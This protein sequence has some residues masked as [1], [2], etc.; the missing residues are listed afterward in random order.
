MSARERTSPGALPESQTSA[1]QDLLT[2]KA[3][4]SNVRTRSS[5]SKSITVASPLRS[6]PPNDSIDVQHS[7]AGDDPAKDDDDDSE[8][9]TVLSSPV[10][11]R[12]ALRR[13]NGVKTELDESSTSIDA[14]VR[15]ASTAKE[16]V[17]NRDGQE[18]GVAVEGDKADSSKGSDEVKPRRKTQKKVVS[19]RREEDSDD[20]SEL[21]DLDEQASNVVSASSKAD[22]EESLPRTKRELL[23]SRKRKYRETSAGRKPVAAE[24]TKRQRRSSAT[25]LNESDRS[26][27]EPP[28]ARL[29]RMKRGDTGNGRDDDKDVAT[30][31]KQN[32]R[33]RRAASH[34]PSREEK[35]SDLWNSDSDSENSGHPSLSRTTRGI[36]RSVS[37]PGRPMPREHK[38]HVNKYGFTRLA[39]A[40]ENGDLDMV[41]EWLEKDREQL[42]IRDNAGNSPLQIASLNGYPEIVQFLLDTGCNKDCANIDNDTP[43]ID[44]VEN[45]HLDVVRVLLDAGVDPLHQN[46]KGQQAL[47]VITDSTDDGPEIR[48]LLK[49][50]IEARQ[51]QGIRA[52]PAAEVDEART[53]R[54]GPKQLLHF[55]A[56]TPENL[57]KLVSNT[58]RNGVIEF[59]NAR[60]PVDN[61]IVAAAAK[62]GD[63]YLINLLLADMSPKKAFSKAE[64]P[65]LAVLGTSHFE[66]VKTLTE[67]EQFDPLWRAKATGKTWHEFA[68]ERSGPHWQQERDL[69]LKLFTEAQ[70]NKQLNSSPR[71]DFKSNSRRQKSPAPSKDSDMDEDEPPD[72]SRTKRR[73]VSRKDLRATTS[74]KSPSTE[75]SAAASSPE[76]VTKEEPA[77]DAQPSKR[78]PGRPRTKSL[79]S[80]PAVELKTKRMKVAREN[81]A[82]FGATQSGNS[83]TRKPSS[84][85]N[86][87]P[88][89]ESL[90]TS[91]RNG[92][93]HNEDTIMTDAKAEEEK[94][95]ALRK[96]AEDASR[97]E[98]AEKAE[99]AARERA[100]A[101]HR[102]LERQRKVASFP[103]ALQYALSE[104]FADETQPVVYLVQHFCP[105]RAVSGRLIGADGPDGEA[106]WMPS[107]QAAGLLRGAAAE[108]LLD[109]NPADGSPA[110]DRKL[111]ASLEKMPFKEDHRRAVRIAIGSTTLAKEKIER[112]LPKDAEDRSN[113]AKRNASKA[114]D[115][116]MDLECQR[117]DTMEP[118]HWIKVKAFLAVKADLVQDQSDAYPHLSQI[119]P[120]ELADTSLNSG[121][122][123]NGVTKNSTP[124]NYTPSSPLSVIDDELKSK[125]GHGLK[126][127]DGEGPRFFT[128]GNTKRF[129]VEVVRDP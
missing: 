49:K 84:S 100:E 55:M 67:L 70:G 101:E 103:T 43:L 126:L 85:S 13:T 97:R 58:D 90:G 121:G 2:S 10:K 76:A 66:V 42:E 78:K 116:R 77:E 6:S 71:S 64:K 22:R 110:T 128:P 57:L 98:E 19:R 111:F 99:K 30:E 69:L 129:R 33:S 37:T 61:N 44:S 88:A 89:A 95:E 51:Q 91:K 65:M 20:D 25:E 39:E 29:R 117:F 52:A 94:A 109:L 26:S 41:K 53:D 7:E 127:G 38:R 35:N 45:G 46:R 8:A 40:C 28:P 120:L 114:F 102:V 83:K 87:R 122:F 62:T 9:E 113:E 24:S 56:R 92:A 75:S 119:P 23:S 108:E 123:G 73:L 118:L 60:V 5:R 72:T 3:G 18:K 74:R 106:L 80:H 115:R 11:R 96:E 48:D 86:H 36:N 63:L 50:A 112:F 54:L 34:L 31:S 104:S 79:S 59:L 82:M 17:E 47:D 105:F 21:S 93:K 124:V 1:P 14:R 81:I 15:R 12:E 68:V 125:I 107:Y 27:T 16:S 32:G 4:D